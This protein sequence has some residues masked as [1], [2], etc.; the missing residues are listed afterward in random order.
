MSN[1][2]L[3]RLVKALVDQPGVQVRPAKSGAWFFYL[4]DGSTATL[5]P[6]QS[7]PR[8][9]RNFRAI[10]RKAGVEW[11]GEKSGERR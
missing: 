6:T 9:M 2:K 1:S 3:S 8:A 7:D 10:I 11:P 4:P 5:H